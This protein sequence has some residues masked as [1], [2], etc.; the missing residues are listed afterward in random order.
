MWVTMNPCVNE[1]HVTQGL[2]R[3]VE[4]VSDR[5]SHFFNFVRLGYFTTVDELHRQDA[6]LGEGPNDFR[7][8]YGTAVE[9]KRRMSA[10]TLYYLF[11]DE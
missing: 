4:G 8:I 6:L 3:C 5:K 10:K 1:D 2:D 11:F 9:S 7:Y